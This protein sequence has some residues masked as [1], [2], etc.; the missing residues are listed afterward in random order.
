VSYDSG[1]KVYGE[2]KIRESGADALII[3]PRLPMDSL[4]HPRNTITKIA[5]YQNVMDV[6][7]SVS[8]VS[9]LLFAVKTLI[10]EDARGVYHVT[11]PGLLHNAELMEWYRQIVDPN[12]TFDLRAP[13]WFYKNDYCREQRSNCVLDT[14]KLMREGIILENTGKMI[15]DMLKIYRDELKTEPLT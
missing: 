4:P 14:S 11:N 8:V 12:H 15:R 3:R 1:T 7:N 6:V 2:M 13:E 9:S 5:S 10:E